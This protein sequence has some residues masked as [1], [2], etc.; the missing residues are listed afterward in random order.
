MAFL[1]TDPQQRQKVL[2]GLLVIGM[3]GYAALEFVHRPRS[4]RVAEL[5]GRL[6]LLL[7]RNQSAR[8]FAADTA[9]AG[10]ERRLAHQHEQ[11]RW[12]ESL[13]PAAEEVADLLDT[14]AAEARHAGIELMLLQPT[15]TSDEHFY[16]RRSYDL[17]VVGHYH[18]IGYFLSRIASLP[19]IIRPRGLSLVPRQQSDHGGSPALEARFSI[20]TYVLPSPALA[21]ADDHAR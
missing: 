21:T 20:E 11:L 2:L 6:E 1:P 4:A 16:S 13:V 18:D 19:R 8:A 5:E 17:A 3:L 7:L 12:I 9:I 15:G 10:L 14:I